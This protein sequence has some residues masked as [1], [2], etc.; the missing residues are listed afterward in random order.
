[1]KR[2]KHSL[3]NY[4]LLSMPMG[5]IIPINWMEVLPGDS[6]QQST[7]A[8]VRVAPLV[9][10]VMHPCQVRIHHWYVP[11]RL[12]WDS[13][14]DFITGGSDGTDETEPP[15]LELGTVAEKSLHDYLGIKPHAYG[16]AM[17]VSAL[18]FR[19]YNLIFNNYYRDQD[20]VDELDID[21][22]D[23]DSGADTTTETDIQNAA[24][25]KDYF[26]TA[27]PWT[28]K[29]SG[30]TIPLGD[31]APITGMGVRATAT[32]VSSGSLR[33]TD[34]SAART[35]VDGWDSSTNALIIEED[36]S[37]AGFPDIRADLSS[38]T[39][40]DISDLRLA[41]AI[42]R[43]QEARARYGSRYVEYLRSL[44]VRSS[45]ARLS[46]P[47]YLGGGRQIIQ[48]SEV[49]STDGSNTG[50]MKG[51]GIAAM[52]TNRYRR[53]FEEHGIVMTMMSVVPKPIYEGALSRS[54]FRKVK[55]D[56]YQRE[57]AAI[58]DQAIT[59][60]E[61]MADHGTPDGNFGYQARYDEY[62]YQPSQVAGEFRSG[63]YNWHMA[64]I[65]GSDVALNQS[66]TDCVPTDRIYANTTYDPLYV[67]A[68]NSI[69]A[70]RQIPRVAKTRT[71]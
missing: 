53:F 64:R 3:S 26:T 2:S 33:E 28:Q 30:V 45:D 60:K 7:S 13:F 69:Q 12:I 9:A 8:L 48:F 32:T 24:W 4:K 71:F 41:L 59:N 21:L 52:R 50:S 55:E 63:L 18:P 68:N 22:T 14:E 70:R 15:Y 1:M 66:F 57:L 5:K 43:Y 40:I 67:M 17:E 31:S 65:F 6:I 25:P 27:R 51:H 36:A 47:E 38:A 54:W 49:L 62:R 35:G 10:P 42:Q 46:L 61:V 58:G 16:G 11:N 29:G 56:Y 34:A 19:A 39:G 37:N 44:G 23:G 20:L